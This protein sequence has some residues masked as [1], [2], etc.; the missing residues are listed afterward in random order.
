MNVDENN[1]NQWSSRCALVYN[2]VHETY[3]RVHGGVYRV[4]TK[5]R[6]KVYNKLFAS[7]KYK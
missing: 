2:S 5:H 3:F 4:F 7:T 1:I 6:K